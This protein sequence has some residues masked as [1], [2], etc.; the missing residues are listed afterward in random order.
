MRR[1]EFI[2]LLGG[3]AVRGP[4]SKAQQTGIPTVGFL[5]TGSSSGWH[6]WIAAFVQR[7]NELGWIDGR[8]ITFEYRWGEGRRERFA[9][10]AGEFVRLKVN[11][12]VTGGSAVPAAQAGDIGHT[13]R[14]HFGDGPDW[15]RPNCEPVATRRERHRIIEPR[16]RSCR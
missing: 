10:I 14:L 3:A 5:G 13:D 1:R 4:A 2:T 15:R 9:E 6:P 11:V 7:L 8:T 16:G 12:I